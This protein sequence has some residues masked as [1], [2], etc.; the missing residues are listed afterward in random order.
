MMALTAQLTRPLRRGTRE[1]RAGMVNSRIVPLG[2]QLPAWRRGFYADH[3]L[4]YDFD[5]HGFDVYVSDLQ[6]ATRFESLNAPRERNL[7]NDKLVTFLFLRH[8]GTPTPTVHGFVSGGHLVGRAIGGES[9]DLHELLRQRGRLVTKPRGGSG[10]VRFCLLE[11]RDGKVMV[12]GHEETDIDACLRGDVIVSDFV[13]QHD[14]ARDIYPEATNT[15]RILALRDPS[16]SEPY[17]AFAI[18]RFGTDRSKPVDNT[19]KGGLTAQIDV[20][21]GALGALAA[22]PGY[23]FAG[24]GRVVWADHHPSTG[25]RVTGVAVPHWDAV[26]SGILGLMRAMSGSHCVGWDVVVTP[27]GFSVI[28]GNNRPDVHHLQV[29]RPLLVDARIRQFFEHHR[30][31]RPGG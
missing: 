2:R 16:T 8:V 30:V 10:G 6:R 5:R 18:H 24:P 17:V 22:M 25:A 21:T 15:L 4:I 27:D 12:N 28:E 7:L 1:L 11:H 19:S 26:T 23:N 20:S 3:S 13:E 29:H 14:Y 31:I 9:P